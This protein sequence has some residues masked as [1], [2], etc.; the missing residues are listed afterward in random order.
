[1]QAGMSL[2]QIGEFSFIIAGVGLS[3]G[4][5]RD[6]LYPVA[7]AVSAITTLTTP[8]L[9]RAAGPVA[10]WVDRKLPPPLQTFV[11]LYGSW[12]ERLRRSGAAA[13]ELSAT[14]RLV[15][16]LLLDAVLIIA[17]VIG[18]SLEA[19]RSAALIHESTG[20]SDRL[21]RA[22]VPTV[23]AI[24]GL[25]LLI[26]LTRTARHL[27]VEL[28]QK[29]I[30]VSK[31]GDVDVGA[32]PRRALVVTLQLAIL[33]VI[34]IPIVAITLPFLPSYRYA[35]APLAL[36]AIP[37]VA[38]WRSA[39]NLQGHAKAGAEVIAMKL[40]SGMADAPADGDDAVAADMERV[41]LALPGLGDP[42]SVRV[43]DSSPASDRT[44]AELN[45][46]GV[47]GATVLAIL[48]DGEQ[49]LVPSGHDRVRS[50]DV[51]A[52]AGS[53]ESVAA[54]RELLIGVGADEMNH[55]R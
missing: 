40:G 21:A 2:A 50:G 44:L 3:S 8:W 5:T 17:I 24:I 31:A 38:F 39:M 7:V 11:S 51:L 18:A 45:L 46:R 29:A 43:G 53:E 33:A 26:G 54:A 6:F 52:V 25:P 34:A 32:A 55:D 22:V 36:V 42:V 47:T 27:G 30:P 19:G 14:R 23:A 20:L 28:A 37:A 10:E 15:R 9:I 12:I 1:V 4:A 41:R 16:L 35:L 48:R 13:P 49:V